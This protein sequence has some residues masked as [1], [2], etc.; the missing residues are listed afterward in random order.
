AAKMAADITGE[1]K[2][3]L[4]EAALAFKKASGQ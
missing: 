1:S 2:N 3:T 4:Y